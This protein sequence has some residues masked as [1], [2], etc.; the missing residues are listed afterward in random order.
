MKPW[1]INNRVNNLSEQIVDYPK[2]DTTIDWNCLSESERQLLY[3]LDEIVK[4]YAPAKPPQDVIEK[5]A[6][7]W[8]K[9]LEIFG[10]RATELFVELVPVSFCCDELEEWY[11]KLYFHNFMLDWLESVQKLRKMPKKQHDELLCERREI[12]MLDMVFR[13]KRYPPLTIQKTS[14]ARRLEQ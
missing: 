4:K 11:F 10:R 7:L 3:K 1:Q 5:Y 14:D 8:Y 6:D 12:G 9:G 2:T 13:L